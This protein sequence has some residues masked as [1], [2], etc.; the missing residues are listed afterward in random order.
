MCFTWTAHGL[1]FSLPRSSHW[2]AGTLID[3]LMAGVEGVGLGVGVLYTQVI[4]SG[5]AAPMDLVWWVHGYG[6][7]WLQDLRGALGAIFHV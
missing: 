6:G 1:P 3:G 7:S 4:L 5:V 2:N